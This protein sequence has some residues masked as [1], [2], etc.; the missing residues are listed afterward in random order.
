MLFVP[1]SD[2]PSEYV[3]RHLIPGIEDRYRPGRIA[4]LIEG[5]PRTGLAICK[6]MDFTATGRE[7]GRLGARLLLVPAWDF[8]VDAWL[9]SRMAI[10]RGVESGFAIARAA[11]DGSLTL[12]DD[13]GRVVAE[14]PSTAEGSVATVVGDVPVRDTT[15]FYARFG[16]WFAQVSLALAAICILLATIPARRSGR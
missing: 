10:L 4:T 5:A 1:G 16:D 14:A 8:K 7:N 11:R 12:S 2:R 6:D 3:K 9:H 15:T 13:R